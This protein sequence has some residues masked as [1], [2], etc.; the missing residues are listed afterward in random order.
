[1]LDYV[2]ELDAAGNYRVTPQYVAKLRK[3]AHDVA[4][5]KEALDIRARVPVLP[6]RMALP[7][8][9]E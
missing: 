4:D 6:S 1:M 3:Y 5:G 8:F 2:T 7:S 9:S